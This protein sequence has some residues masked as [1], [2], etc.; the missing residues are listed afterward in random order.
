M[1]ILF[2]GAWDSIQSFFFGLMLI[3]DGFVY[4]AISTLYKV[5]MILAGQRILTTEAFTVIANK[6]Y[7]IIGVAMLFVL[8]Y[9][10]LRA[11]IDP[12]QLTKGELGGTKI[13]KGV[14][15]CV[16]GLALT[17]VLFNLIYQGQD[18]IL[19]Q[20]IIGK[21]FF[22]SDEN[23]INYEDV[24]VEDVKVAEANEVNVDDAMYSSAGNVVAIYI[25][26]AFFHP[27]PDMDLK[28]EQIEG[29][30]D[31]YIVNPSSAFLLGAGLGAATAVGTAVSSA[32][33]AAAAGGTTFAAAFSLGFP[34][35]AIA[36]LIGGIIFAG[37]TGLADGLI[38]ADTM[39]LAEAI[40]SVT[41]TG[42]FGLFQIFAESCAKGEINYFWGVS[43]IVGIFVCYAF[44]SFSIDMAVRSAKLAYYQII[45][46]VP[47]IL[48]I[49]PKFQK[50]FSK[51]ISNIISTFVEVFVRLSVIYVVVYI[52]SHLNTLVA[53]D[54]ALWANENIGLVVGLFARVLLIM[55]LIIFAKQAPKI[56]SETF[57]ID[58][59]N[60]SIGLGRKLS[61]GGL[62]AAGGVIGATATAGVQNFRNAFGKAYA[63][64]KSFTGVG[65][66]L[67]SGASS[68][69][70]GG[71]S[72]GSRTARRAVFDHATGKPWKAHDM[73][74]G[75]SRGAKEATD[76]RDQRAKYREEHGGNL[77]G[78]MFGHVN[79][80]KDRVVNW[81]TG[82]VDT[83]YFDGQIK[84]YDN[85]KGIEK[86]LEATVS[87]DRKVKDAE[88]K[89]AILNNA[90][91]ADY[92]YAVDLRKKAQANTQTSIDDLEKRAGEAD[93][94]YRSR[95]G[96]S[97]TADI[98]AYK[99]EKTEEIIRAEMDNLRNTSFLRK[100]YS[101]DR[102]S[103]SY[104]EGLKILQDE[105]A[106]ADTELRDAKRDAVA[107]KLAEAAASGVENDTSRKLQ[108]LMSSLQGDIRKYSNV[109]VQVGI[110]PNTNAPIFERLGSILEN[111]F[112][113]EIGSGRVDLGTIIN[114]ESGGIA[115]DFEITSSD[116][117][118]GIYTYSYNTNSN[119]FEYAWKS[120]DNLGDGTADNFLENKKIEKSSLSGGGNAN[121]ITLQTKDTFEKAKDNLV[122]S[123]EYQ[124]AI[125]RKRK[126]EEKK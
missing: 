33:G 110:D 70:A 19:E 69:V 6:I 80:V 15:T 54:A 53:S 111:Q 59:G 95:I 50:N 125:T 44:V 85:L 31:D 64:D 25:W 4:S 23:V 10:I 46:P 82:T 11:I 94:V 14:L 27:N 90:D 83:S 35:L 3:L 42:S 105:M 30:L 76:A 17:P 117:K 41:G 103:K 114:M 62:F 63:R 1:N 36:A 102:T 22:A 106:T 72:A 48:Q 121:P 97:A 55:G 77:G 7:I 68:G 88:N 2:L 120:G 12:D 84:L 56:I 119:K 71:V 73:V 60:M 29:E 47:L 66:A 21:M 118:K 126:Q 108:S 101:V 93:D 79:D 13:L 104:Q 115:Y 122:K 89:R 124:D 58:S 37:A 98:E 99:A 40:A 28:A 67:L 107:R 100:D 39:N 9:A 45:A 109:Q 74:Q 91:A 113:A 16:L 20:N 61:E 87:S 112:G 51:W 24:Y 78:V 43:T 96:A 65:K 75:A 5:Y 52:I 32:V 57:G 8:A 18:I 26:Q 34:A 49:L 123:P 81:S 92:A 86:D 116:G 38:A